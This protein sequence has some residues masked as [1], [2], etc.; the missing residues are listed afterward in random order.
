M[1]GILKESKS[2]AIPDEIIMGKIYL[3]R[4]KK[5]LLDK[6]LAELYGVDTKQLKRAVR[7]N[8]TRFPEDF[9]FELNA[10][11]FND[12]RRQFGTSSWGGVRY[13]PMAFTEYGVLMLAS[14]LNSERAISVNIQVVRIFTR[15]REMLTSHSEILH[16]LE[17]IEEKMGEHDNQILLIFEYLKQLEGYRQQELEQKTRKRIGFKPSG[18]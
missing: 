14:V 10:N 7:R 17:K 8:I 6:D 18:R 12:L 5:I 15:M 16:R 4:G 9:M 3:I 2:I 13:L 1:A 11:E